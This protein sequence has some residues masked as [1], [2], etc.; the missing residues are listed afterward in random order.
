MLQL[1]HG[2]INVGDG[3][4]THA[5]QSLGCVGTVFLGQPVVIRA[6]DRFVC[7]V[8]SD[9]APEARPH[10]AGKQHLCINAVL[11]LLLQALFRRAGPGRGFVVLPG[12]RI[13]RSS[14]FI[15]QSARDVGNKSLQRLALLKYGKGPV[16]KSD[17]F[18]RPITIFCRHPLGISIGPNLQMRIRRNAPVLHFLPL[19]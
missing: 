1:V 15:G 7:V 16:L 6:D 19:S 4:D 3:N 9:A 2:I 5:N 8:V 12:H 13:E 17:D 11:G 18:W 10:V 14:L